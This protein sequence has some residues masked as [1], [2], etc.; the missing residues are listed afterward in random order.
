[1]ALCFLHVL[2]IHSNQS[3]APSPSLFTCSGCYGPA[4]GHADTQGCRM[5]LLLS[6]WGPEMPF[7]GIPLRCEKLLNT[8]KDSIP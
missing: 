8:G 4:F 1:M 2:R 5:D 6:H 7:P 3:L